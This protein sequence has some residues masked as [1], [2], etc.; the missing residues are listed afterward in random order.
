MIIHLFSYIY[1]YGRAYNLPGGTYFEVANNAGGPMDFE[2]HSFTMLF[3]LMPTDLGSIAAYRNSDNTQDWW[4][5][6]SGSLGPESNAAVR[7]KFK[8]RG[9]SDFSDDSLE[10][11]LS[12]SD[13]VMT[14]RWNY[15]GVAFDHIR[16]KAH[17]IIEGEIVDTTDVTCANGLATDKAKFAIGIPNM[18]MACTQ[19]YKTVLTRQQLHSVRRCPMT[20]SSNAVALFNFPFDYSFGKGLF[21][22]S[23]VFWTSSA[24]YQSTGGPPW[25]KNFYATKFVGNGHV[26]NNNL[27]TSMRITSTPFT[28]SMWVRNDETGGTNRPII[29]MTGNGG[30]K[31]AVYQH[32]STGL[33]EF[34]MACTEGLKS[35]TGGTVAYA[36]DT[37]NHIV[38]T[39]GNNYIRKFLNGDPIEFIDI[40]SCDLLDVTQLSIGFVIEFFFIFEKTNLLF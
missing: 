39:V 22:D 26:T 14:G 24:N 30:A 27:P 5:T 28:L 36:Y 35:A 37:W 38:I 21:D 12:N 34:Q 40:G 8:C 3:H 15:M 1:C 10:L 33:I 29:V 2:A 7:F 17:L 11:Y 9:E 32:P 18:Q 16:K 6:N 23:S 19:F 31:I 4:F 25:T 20:T 13:K